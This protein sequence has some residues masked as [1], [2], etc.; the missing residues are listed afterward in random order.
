[1]KWKSIFNDTILQSGNLNIWSEFSAVEMFGGKLAS[2]W[3]PLQ[4]N[5]KNLFGFLDLSP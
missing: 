2:S 5:N 1:M 3:F 4:K